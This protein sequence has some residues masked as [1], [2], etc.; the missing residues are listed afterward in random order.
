[1]TCSSV[2]N[3]F[4]RGIC[5][6]KLGLGNPLGSSLGVLLT[7]IL[8]LTFVG[9]EVVSFRLGFGTPLGSRLGT[10]VTSMLALHLFE[11]GFFLLG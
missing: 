2:L 11:Q 10:F 3:L 1:M 7:S 6:F 4:T 8:V 5:Y 9:K